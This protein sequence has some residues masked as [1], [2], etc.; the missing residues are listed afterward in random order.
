M[1]HE[2]LHPLAPPQV[3]EF[4]VQNAGEY[5]GPASSSAFTDP[6][7]GGAKYVPESSSSR[8]TTGQGGADPFTGTTTETQEV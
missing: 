4:I 3:A 6:F 8:R 2:C 5:T 1:I 7:T